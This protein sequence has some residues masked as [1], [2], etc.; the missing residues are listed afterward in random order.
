MLGRVAGYSK[1]IDE[2][3]ASLLSTESI[4]SGTC[5]V[6]VTELGHVF[7]DTLGSAYPIIE[8]TYRSR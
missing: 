7:G 8:G 1:S 6:D 2:S 4:H 3:L 5:K